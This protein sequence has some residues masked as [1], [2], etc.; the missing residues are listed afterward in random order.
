MGKTCETV[1]GHEGCTTASERDRGCREDPLVGCCLGNLQDEA[2]PLGILEMNPPQRLLVV[3]TGFRQSG[4][5]QVELAESL[6][7]PHQCE[8][9]TRCGSVRIQRFRPGLELLRLI[10]GK[11]GSNGYGSNPTGVVGVTEQEERVNANT[12]LDGLV[13]SATHAR[14][15][16]VRW[17]AHRLRIEA[18]K[19]DG[20]TDHASGDLG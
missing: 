16:C 15:S 4:N 3:S 17:Q 13:G 10:T 18:V 5:L 8:I 11:R 14:K 12:A 1:V 20:F 2:I 9:D 6:R 7:C 19:T